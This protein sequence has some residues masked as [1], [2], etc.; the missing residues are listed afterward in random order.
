MSRKMSVN[1]FNPRPSSFHYKGETFKLKKFSLAAQVWADSEF[2]N[3]QE[4][5][6]LVNLSSDMVNLNSNSI[7]KVCY[8]LL[9][10]KTRFSDHS[11]LLDFFSDEYK[12][13]AT[14]LKPVSECIAGSQPTADDIS[15]E[16]IELKK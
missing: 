3:D 10:D 11:E 7:A 16:E 9:E 14:V 2:S 5:S 15:E 1:E 4:K 13:L 6:G 8:Y 12:F